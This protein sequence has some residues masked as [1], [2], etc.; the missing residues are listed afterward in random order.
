MKFKSPVYSSASGAIA[1]LVYSHNSGGLY[2]RSRAVPTNPSSPQQVAVRNAV[3]GLSNYWSSVLTAAQRDAWNVYA[4]NVPLVGPLG[5]ARQVSGIAQ[6]VRSNVPRIQASLTR[7]DDGPST[8]TVGSFTNPTLTGVASTGVISIAFTNT[9][10]WANAAGGAML[11]YTS[12]PQS[13]GITFFAGPYQYTG[14][15]AG[16]ATPPTSP[17]TVTS[18]FTLTAGQKVFY[19]VEVSQADGRLSAAFRGSFNA[20]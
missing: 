13:V 7:V 17:A 8:F 4:A 14:K 11:V 6:Y 3:A 20:T 1:G 9:D 15:I 5:D 18:P 12:R 2:T 10:D 19:R 16:A